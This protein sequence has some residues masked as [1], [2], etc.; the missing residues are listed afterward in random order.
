MKCNCQRIRCGTASVIESYCLWKSDRSC[1]RSNCCLGICI[2]RLFCCRINRS[3]GADLSQR[4]GQALLRCTLT[5]AGRSCIIF[6]TSTGG[7]T[8]RR[9]PRCG[10]SAGII[11]VTFVF[12]TRLCC[13]TGIIPVTFV[14]IFTRLYCSTGM[15]AVA[16]I[17]IFA[18]FRRSGRRR[19]L[20][21]SRSCTLSQCNAYHLTACG[22]FAEVG[23]IHIC[24]G[25]FACGYFALQQWNG[26]LQSTFLRYIFFRS[27]LYRSIDLSFRLDLIFD[28][29]FFVL[30]LVFDSYL[31]GTLFHCIGSCLFQSNC[32]FSCFDLINIDDAILVLIFISGGFCIFLI[33]FYT[34]REL[35]TGHKLGFLILN[36]NL[37]ILLDRSTCKRKLFLIFL[38]RLFLFF[39]LLFFHRLLFCCFLFRLRTRILD[40]LGFCYFFRKAF[41]PIDHITSCTNTSGCNNSCQDQ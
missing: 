26:I 27:I 12:F 21:S 33:R 16:F 3:H 13:S 28:I 14:I 5:F 7:T 10:W 29:Y 23:Y 20:R 4:C 35:L 6:C 8:F 41:I 34:D 25:Y 30:D 2:R 37:Q 39:D 18:R 40:H 9:S 31:H 22:C 38:N 15:I 36:L 32:V 19:R 1:C 11:P 17:I 24:T